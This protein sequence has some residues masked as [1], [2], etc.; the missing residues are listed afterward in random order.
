MILLVFA[1]EIEAKPFLDYHDL[2]KQHESSPYEL[3]EKGNISLIITGMGSIKGTV[4]LSDLIQKKKREGISI[5]KMT[6][7]GIVGC[8]TDKFCIG[9]VVEIDK[10]IKYNPVEFSKPKPSEHF[11]SSY[12]EII[13][14][15]KKGDLNTLATSDHPIFIEEDSKRIAKYAH[16]VDMEGYGYAFVAKYYNIPI[17]LIKGISDFAFKQSEEAFRQNVKKCLSKLLTFHSSREALKE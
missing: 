16:F 14:N 15:K 3:C 10:V 5:T 11:L 17:T 7:Y 6:N 12:P 2:K 1:T 9:D 8:L 13:V 4:Y